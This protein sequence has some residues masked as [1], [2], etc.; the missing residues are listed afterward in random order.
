MNYGFDPKASKSMLKANTPDYSLYFNY[1][2][3]GGK[4]T[5][6]CASTGRKL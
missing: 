1:K 3:D 2:N 6:Y 4:N 5:F